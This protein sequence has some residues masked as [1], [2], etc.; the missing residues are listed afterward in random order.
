M[1]KAIKKTEKNLK[2]LE[3]PS[4]KNAVLVFSLPDDQ[5]DYDMAMKASDYNCALNEIFDKCRSLLKHGPGFKNIT[6]AHA[7]VEEIKKM[8]A[9]HMDY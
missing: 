1:A 2:T 3:L 7:F 5:Y 6:E 8:S 9:I 4:G